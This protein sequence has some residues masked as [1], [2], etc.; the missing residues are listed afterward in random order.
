LSGRDFVVEF[1][2]CFETRFGLFETVELQKGLT[3]IYGHCGVFRSQTT[4]NLEATDSLI[5]ASL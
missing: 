2:R 5:E 1:E 4:G 3:H